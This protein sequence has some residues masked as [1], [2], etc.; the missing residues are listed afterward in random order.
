MLDLTMPH[1]RA[2]LSAPAPELMARLGHDLAQ[3]T[4]L[5]P[6]ERIDAL[7]RDQQSRWERG[8]CVG[9]EL[10]RLAAPQA[11]G[12]DDTLLYLISGELRLRGAAG[13]RLDA[14]EY[15]SRFPQLGDT[16]A[17]QIEVE[18]ALL[19][20]EQAG[21]LSA[22]STL[23]LVSQAPRVTPELA[24]VP[25]YEV[26]GEL[27]RGGMGV[28][29]KARDINL[30]RLVALKMILPGKGQAQATRERFRREAVHIAQLKHA[31]IVPV[32]GYGEHEGNIYFALEY[33]SGGSLH[34]KLQKG[35]GKPWAFPDAARLVATLA[36]AVAYAHDRKIIHRDLKPAN[37]LLDEGGQPHVTD[38]G[39]AR[40]VESHGNTLDGA[41]VGTPAYMAP[42]QANGKTECI[43]PAADIFGLGAILYQLLTGRPPYQGVDVRT[44]LKQAEQGRVV[45]VREANP[46]VP[47]SLARIVDRA[48]AHEP[49]DRFQTAHDLQKALEG[50]LVPS[51][52]WLIGLAA[53][54]V[55]LIT[56]SVGLAVADPW[57]TFQKGAIVKPNPDTSPEPDPPKVPLNG[58]FK[59]T[60]YSKTDKNRQ[61]RVLS[62]ASILPL[63]SGELIQFHAELNR[64][65]HVYVLWIEGSTGDIDPF[66]PWDRHDPDALKKEAPPVP[67]TARVRMPPQLDHGF[68]MQGDS[69]LETVILMARETPL[70]PNVHLGEVLGP[71]PKAPLNEP[72]EFVMRGVNR[73]DPNAKDGPTRGAKE[74]DIGDGLRGVELPPFNRMRGAGK[75]P[76]AIDEPVL[77]LMRKVSK[78]FD[79]VRAVRFAYKK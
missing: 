13:E 59:L 37:I 70:P 38:F 71:I 53:A 69:G 56:G 26:L 72:G 62:D 51:S 11:V 3:I 39:L 6:P 79:V 16:I 66:Y 23:T 34:Q 24:G 58:D 40:Q 50:Y 63:R 4:P 15:Q 20:T 10:Y 78:H 65:A 42:E 68:P 19:S 76:E 44:T 43:G 25:G 22:Y 33:I 47:R 77:R 5:P 27:G 35:D 7:L 32:Y 73:V 14:R 52:G 2:L 55:V 8:E 1:S 46:K 54:S 29:F 61:G 17:R 74:F 48:L 9:A 49:K 21:A 67:K 60:V 31:N 28:V 75:D 12:D 18:T 57:Q 30:D 41:V 64:P 36:G 45:P